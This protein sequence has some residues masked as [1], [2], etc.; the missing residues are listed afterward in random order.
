MKLSALKPDLSDPEDRQGHRAHFAIMLMA[1]VVGTLILL[2]FFSLRT[3]ALLTLIAGQAS[4]LFKEGWDNTRPGGS[5]W[6]WSDV[7]AGEL[8]LLP[9]IVAYLALAAAVA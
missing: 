7:V 8:G 6:S 5:G 3:A 1:G 9:P 4:I 2:P